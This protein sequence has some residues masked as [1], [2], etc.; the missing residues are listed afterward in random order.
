M[1][2]GIDRIDWRLL[3]HNYGAAADIPD[4]L[5]R[6]ADRDAATAEEAIDELDNAL[7]HQGGWICSAAPAT[8]PYLVELAADVATH[9]R[10]ALVELIGRLAR[11]AA[12]VRRR[13]VDPGWQ[14]A[15][16]AVR[17]RVLA[18]LADPD[19]VVRREATFLAAEGV[20]HPDTVTAL[21][22][23][24]REETD[25][26]TRW[27]LVLAFGV[28]HAW[29]PDDEC[30]AELV[31]LLTDDDLQVR[32]AAVHALAE[33]DPR[34]AAEHVDILVR[35]VRD[36]EVELWRDSAW[37]GGNRATIVHSAGSLLA[38]EPVAARAFAIGVGQGGGTDERVAAITQAG[39]VLAEWRTATDSIMPFVADHLA[40]E[41]AEVR[42]RAAFLLGCLGPLATEHADR[43]AGLSADPASGRSGMVGDAAVWALA[44]LHDSR[45]V[46]PLVE[47]LT[48]PRLGF[49]TV[50]S[51][52]PRDGHVVSLPGVH[53]VLI[54]LSGHADALLDAVVT[55]LETEQ[56]RY[57]AS[58]LCAVLGA[59]GPAAA[60]AVPVLERLL[61]RFATLPSAA[62]ALGAIGPAAAGCAEGLTRTPDIPETAWALWR[63]GVDPRGGAKTLVDHVVAGAGHDAVRLLADLGPAA[64]RA[65]DTVR[66]LRR[67]GGDWQRVESAHALWRI[68]GDPAEAL[69]VLTDEVRPLVDGDV[70]PVRRAALRYLADMEAATEPVLAVAR[71]VEDSPR[72]L[73]DSGG[74]RTFVQDEELRA[75]AA[76]LTRSR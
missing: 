64:A 16:D 56:D 14:P 75:A 33:S 23:R 59:W 38:D 69:A 17:P 67:S 66:E 48:G 13:Y 9:H 31:R 50:A 21:W 35:A 26:V 43:L 72:R 12:T 39:A 32:L 54:P 71:A 25:R 60:P 70:L 1:W 5:R 8:L 55:R 28:A 58:N 51:H 74:W 19:P 7:F 40:D 29:Q 11:E 45:C 63:T 2:E 68:T 34:A 4:L 15:L 36:P 52:F 65:V 73:A 41:A 44:R 49:G 20:R 3:E 46:P 10:A 76:T 30:H 18:L 61:F 42:Y 47:R 57:L 24:W 27:D 53:E 62:K 22:Q 6:C 37:I